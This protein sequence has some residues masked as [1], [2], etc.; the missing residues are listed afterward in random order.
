MPTPPRSVLGCALPVIIG[1]G[2][3]AGRQPQDPGVVGDGQLAAVVETI[4]AD[5]GLPAFAA[6]LVRRGATLEEAAVGSRAAANAASVTL[7]DQWHIG[8][9]TKAMTATLDEL[10]RH[11]GGTVEDITRA[12]PWPTLFTDS[13]PILAHAGPQGTDGA[14][15]VLIACYDAVCPPGN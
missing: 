12:A 1:C 3:A 6:I 8:S 5:H 11:V 2:G 15:V 9:L 13:R 7:A 14:I 4:R 10:L